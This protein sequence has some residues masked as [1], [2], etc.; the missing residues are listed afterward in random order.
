[1]A[2]DLTLCS[3]VCICHCWLWKNTFQLQTP[4][5]SPTRKH[6][7]THSQTQL[8]LFTLSPYITTI[9]ALGCCHGNLPHTL[10]EGIIYSCLRCGIINNLHND[11]PC[12]QLCRKLQ[13]PRQHFYFTHLFCSS[14]SVLSSPK[15][16]IT[17]TQEAEIGNKFSEAQRQPN[18]R[19]AG[20]RKRHT[21]RERG[22][23]VEENTALISLHVQHLLVFVCL[24]RTKGD[25]R[26]GARSHSAHSAHLSFSERLWVSAKHI[27]LHFCEHIHIIW[28]YIDSL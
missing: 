3:S 2:L 9:G 10:K 12:K 7:N 1:M 5:P 14:S 21:R 11:H 19:S 8:H 16:V 20:L 27:N 25:N 24:Y 26:L 22:L 18:Y 17:L 13:I 28:R 4:S 15:S 6:T 23:P